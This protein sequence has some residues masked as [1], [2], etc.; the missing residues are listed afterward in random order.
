MAGERSGSAPDASGEYGTYEVHEA[1]EARG[2]GRAV[3]APYPD[4]VPV[5]ARAARALEALGATEPRFEVHATGGAGWLAEWDGELRGSEVGITFEG[6]GPDAPDVRLFLGRW[7][8]ECIP[9][10]DLP[11]LLTAA[12]TGRAAITVERWLYF[13]RVDVLT[14]TV[15][16]QAYSAGE[17]HD[18]ERRW[19]PWENDL[20][21][22]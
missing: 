20:R 3:R 12:F 18:P 5:V 19:S 4:E 17:G 15:G 16:E 13:W 1:D 8:F 22:A 21:T 9:A 7:T 14:V 11:D 10:A 6:A 2:R